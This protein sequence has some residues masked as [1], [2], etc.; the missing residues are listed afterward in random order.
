MVS[1]RNATVASWF[2]SDWWDNG[3]NQI[4]FGRGDKGFVVINKESSSLTRTF[5]TSLPAGSYCEIISGDFTPSTGGAPAS[6]TGTQLIVDP[7]GRVTLTVGS[8]AAAAIHAGAR[9]DGAIGPP[10]STVTVTFNEAADTSFGTNLYV[11]GS[12]DALAQW[13]TDS[14]P[15]LTWL[16]GTGTRG[17]WR[18]T[19]T[20]PASTSVEYKYIKKDAGGNITWESGSNRTFTTTAGGT[21]QTLNDS[22]K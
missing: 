22:W 3:G 11:V 21:S 13:H 5:Q 4:A 1:F 14:A 18:T 17:N 9:L 10:P 2:T 16:N 12:I 8:F 7:Q 6:C 15:P 20:L 19:L